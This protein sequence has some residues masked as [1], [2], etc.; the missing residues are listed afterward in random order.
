MTMAT[1]TRTTKAGP[2]TRSI[3]ISF[4][5]ADRCEVCVRGTQN[6]LTTTDTYLLSRQPSDFGIAFSV[7]EVDAEG[8]RY[9]VLLNAPGGRHTCDCK[10]A[11]TRV[12]SSRAVTS[13]WRYKPCGNASSNHGNHGGPLAP[14]LHWRTNY[15]GSSISAWRFW[16]WY[17]PDVV[18]L[19]RP[20]R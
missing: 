13:R 16:L 5:L 1:A 6:N 9:D 2:I 14:V 11:P 8:E 17:W 20:W 3:T 18:R 19:G 7:R 12:T 10:W 4:A 15:E